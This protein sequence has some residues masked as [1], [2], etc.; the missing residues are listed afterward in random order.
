MHL[1]TRLAKAALV[2]VACGMGACSRMGD[3]PE[4]VVRRAGKALRDRNRA[5]FYDQVDLKALESQVV[6]DIRATDPD[7]YNTMRALTGTG[8]GDLLG[9]R[10]AP[11]F[12]SPPDTSRDGHLTA[13][14]LSTQLLGTGMGVRGRGKAQ[15]SGRTAFV[16]VYV[17]VGPDT[18]PAQVAVQLARQDSRWRIVGVHDIGPALQGERRRSTLARGE[19][20]TA[21]P[22]ENAR[23]AGMRSDL[24]NLAT[25]QEAYFSD[26]TTYANSISQLGTQYY[27]STGI[28]VTILNGS[29]KGWSASATHVSFPG[30]ICYIYIG[31]PE[32]LPPDTTGV[33]HEGAPYCKPRK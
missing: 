25:N 28:T 23:L 6:A 2:L 14:V 5:E 8:S 1:T 24:R 29:A 27:P 12:T 31:T 21:T 9:R 20:Y 32:S 33:Q 17:E 13:T 3:S 22:Q 15:I 10:L 18:V 26:H 19:V 7:P 4:S 11:I 16:P 30:A